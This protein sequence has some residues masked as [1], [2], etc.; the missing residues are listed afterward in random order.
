[1]DEVRWIVAPGGAL[2]A[3]RPSNHSFRLIQ[4]RVF[5]IDTQS[6]AGFPSTSRQ[7]I[8]LSALGT[9]SRNFKVDSIASLLNSPHHIADPDHYFPLE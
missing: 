5:S 2:R 3:A 7:N 1:M 8:R 6:L 4:N 9:R